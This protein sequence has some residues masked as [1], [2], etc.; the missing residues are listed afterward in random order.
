LINTQTAK[1]GG[2]PKGRVDGAVIVLLAV[3]LGILAGVY[4]PVCLKFLPL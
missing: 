3:V 4:G 2:G 1:K